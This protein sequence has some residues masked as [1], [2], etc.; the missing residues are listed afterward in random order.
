MM[1]VY[2]CDYNQYIDAWKNL[3]DGR[4]PVR[5]SGRIREAERS[6][7]N[8]EYYFYGDERFGC[9]AFPL[10]PKSGNDT[11]RY[12]ASA[13]IDTIIDFEK[14]QSIN[15]YTVLLMNCE[16]KG[17]RYIKSRS[18]PY[19]M[20]RDNN[21]TKYA[22]F[23]SEGMH[24][25][26]KYTYINKEPAIYL[27]TTQV[28]YIS[29]YTAGLLIWIII[30]I[31]WLGNTCIF[32]HERGIKLQWHMSIVVVMKPFVLAYRLLFWDTVRLRKYELK[33]DF[34]M[35]MTLSTYTLYYCLLW[36]TLIRI[37][38]GWMITKLRLSP[39]GRFHLYIS[40]IVWGFGN[41]VFNYFYLFRNEGISIIS[42]DLSTDMVAYYMIAFALLATGVSYT[43]ILM[44]VCLATSNLSHQMSDQIH[45][46]RTLGMPSSGTAVANR[47]KMFV[48]MSVGFTCYLLALFIAWFSVLA[49][50]DSALYYPWLN[51]C[52]EEILEII[53]VLWVLITFRARKFNTV[54]LQTRNMRGGGEGPVYEMGNRDDVE[55]V[56]STRVCIVNPTED[57]DA[58]MTKLSFGVPAK[59]R[60]KMIKST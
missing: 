5:V 38:H 11:V 43:I 25:T 4:R 34:L 17:T 52:V 19:S 2:L 58:Y 13:T 31:I 21:C 53:F 3:L 22:P 60:T 36:E 9:Q 59:P 6:I 42:V 56:V 54:A 45:A 29:M 40:V 51:G 37:S 30:A 33:L 7:C 10:R 23:S 39:Q 12:T 35:V 27:S 14:E 32:R 18:C 8:S 20:E 16:I 50:E 26:V 15:Y 49:I 46:L 28:P 47:K 55:P 48:Q 1:Y 57:E 44:T 24:Y 41:F